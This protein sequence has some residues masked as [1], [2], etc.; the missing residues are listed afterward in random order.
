MINNNTSSLVARGKVFAVAPMMDWEDKAKK[1][2]IYKAACAQHVQCQVAVTFY[3]FGSIVPEISD[4][5]LVFETLDK[6]LGAY[7]TF[8]LFATSMKARSF[9]AIDARLGKYRDWPLSSMQKRVKISTSCPIRRS[10]R[11]TGSNV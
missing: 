6:K 2:N 7:E 3:E 8:K 9:G 1:S 11:T 5:N 10:S 4:G